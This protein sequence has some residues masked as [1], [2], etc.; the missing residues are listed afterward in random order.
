MTQTWTP[1]KRPARLER[2]L[3]FVDYEA[4]REFLERAADLSE[5][6]DI[7]PDLSFGRTHVNLTLHASEAGGEVEPALRD[8]AADLDRIVD[9]MAAAE[10]GILDGQGSRN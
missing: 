7:Y 5:A 4:T 1:R 6:R 10:E 2:R 9:D 3:E 8:F